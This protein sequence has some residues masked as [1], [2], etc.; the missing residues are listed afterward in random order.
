MR[1][2]HFQA[3]RSKAIGL[4]AGVALSAASVLPQMCLAQSA[5]PVSRFEF[6]LAGGRLAAGDKTVRVAKGDAVELRWTSDRAVEL[7]LHGYDVQVRAGPESP[8]VM[9][10][11]AHATGRFPVEIHGSSGRHTTLVYV[12]VHPR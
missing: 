5:A 12:E 8:K 10:F 1:D 2:V 4:L 3:G 11:E 9:R 6:Q 7:H